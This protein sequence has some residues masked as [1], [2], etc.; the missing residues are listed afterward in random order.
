MNGGWGTT[1]G[2]GV[3]QG[4]TTLAGSKGQS[5]RLLEAILLQFGQF[6]DI[7]NYFMIVFR[8]IRFITNYGHILWYIHEIHNLSFFV[9][10]SFILSLIQLL[11][12][13][14]PLIYFNLKVSS[15]FSEFQ[16]LSY[17]KSL[18]KIEV[19][20]DICKWRFCEGHDK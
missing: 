2:S 6:W 7:Q 16:V 20:Y 19:F 10:V 3:V 11:I 18:R 9:F 15:R 4:V 1:P 12:L 8:Q 17:H 5:P 14:V 13:G